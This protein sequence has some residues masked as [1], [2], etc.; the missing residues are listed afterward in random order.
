MRKVLTTYM[1]ALAAAVFYLLAFPAEIA[2]NR[3]VKIDTVK[4]HLVVP[5]PALE[6][7]KSL[8]TSPSDPIDTLDTANEHIKV[9][10]HADNTWHYYKTPG[11]QQV[12]GVYDD[13]WNDNTT[14]PYGIEQ[15]ELPDQ[16]SIWL[17]DSLD[18][19]HCPFQGSVYYRGKFGPRRGRRHQGVDLPLKVGDPIYAAFTGKVRVSKYWGAFGNLVIIRHDNGLETF[20]AHLS[21]RNVE[22]GDWVNAGDVIGL[23]GSTGRS[24]GPHLHFET[25]YNGFAFD[26][27]WLIDFE[28]GILRHRLFVLKKKY[29][30]I[31]SN[32][33][34]DFEDEMK[35]EEDD[36]KEDAEREAMRWYT[37]KSGDTLGRIAINHGTTVSALC[38]LN[39]ITPKTTLKIGRK[40]RV[41]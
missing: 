20:Y 15:S 34:Q 2:A 9:V 27:Q 16:W 32:Y 37:I 13:H 8:I 14:N 31:Y 41:R 17:V 21:K 1:A 25:R 24:T 10:L 23:G 6:P 7:V 38:K 4:T 33:E 12:T 18:Q 22:V 3:P 40:I 39:G 28:K 19:Y 26:P 36:K 35:N 30:N 5:R 29:F 11:F